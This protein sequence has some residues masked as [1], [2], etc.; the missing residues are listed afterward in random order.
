[1]IT[2]ITRLALALAL[3]V[4]L[5]QLAAA[6]KK[7]PAEIEAE[8]GREAAKEIEKEYKVVDRPA[9]LARINRIVSVLAPIVETTTPKTKVVKPTA[10]PDPA[11]GATP[12][13]GNLPLTTYTAK[14]LQVDE[15]NAISLPGG[16]IYVTTGL[17]GAVESDDELAAV[18]AH[19]MAHNAEQHSLKLTKRDK[20]L[21]KEMVLAILAAVIAASATSNSSRSS[22]SQDQSV[23]VFEVVAMGQAVRA[24]IINGYGIEAEREAD[25]DALQYMLKSPYQPVA[26]LTVLEGLTRMAE[27]RPPVE[28]GYLQTHP[29]P[30]ERMNRIEQQLRE[31]KIPINRRLVT[32][33]LEASAETVKVKDREIAQVTIA[34]KPVFQ[35]AAMLGDKTPLQR[36]GE[37]AE[38]INLALRENMQVFDLRTVAKGNLMEV[39]GRDRVL[40]TIAPGDA[41]FHGV[42]A[43]ELANQSVAALRM[44]F[45]REMVERGV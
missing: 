16:Y 23:G 17:L 38:Q 32:K 19:E 18:L 5:P 22:E 28:F 15:P 33:A 43:Q 11:Q 4:M 3:L 45:W 8:I 44:A 30:R 31:L 13:A 34:S 39:R 41:A 29:A 27:S 14:V 24:A 40:I 26:L 6:A 1:M 21:N 2:R 42:T 12:G 36:A 9:D 37:M 7:T 10:S 25:D 35:P 20:K